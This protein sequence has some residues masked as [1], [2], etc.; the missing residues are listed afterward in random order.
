[1]FASQRTVM[2]ETPSSLVFPRKLDTALRDTSVKSF[3]A[4]FEMNKSTD[5]DMFINDN[6]QI[7]WDEDMIKNS[8]SSF[9]SRILLHILTLSQNGILFTKKKIADIGQIFSLLKDTTQIQLQWMLN[10]NFLPNKEIL[11]TKIKR[12]FATRQS[13]VVLQNILSIAQ[14]FADLIEKTQKIKRQY[15]KSKRGADR[16]EAVIKENHVRIDQIGLDVVWSERLIAFKFKE[17]WYIHSYAYLLLIHNKL[18]DLLSVLVYSIHAEGNALEL[19][20][21]ETTIEFVKLLC[22]YNITYGNKFFGIAK[23]LEAL[24][25]AETLRQLEEWDNTLFLK[26]LQS[27]LEE[28]VG[29]SYMDSMLCIILRKATIPFRHELAGLS[30]IVG[31]PYVDMKSGTAKLHEK[32]TKTLELDEIAIHETV[33]HAKRMFIKNYICRHHKW[34]NVEMSE[35]C[36]ESIR[37]AIEN[38]RDPDA[39]SGKRGKA[40]VLLSD[41][42]HISILKCMEFE[43]LENFIPYLKDKTVS[44][45][46]KEV[47]SEI[48]E[49]K[50]RDIGEGTMNFKW[51]E[52]RLLLV[53]LLNPAVVTDHVEFMKRYEITTDFQDLLNYLVIRIVPK[54]KELKEDYRG[55]GCKTVPER[56]RGQTQESNVK[57]Y[58][59][60]YVTESAMPLG[61]LELANRLLSFR[62]IGKAYSGYKVLRINV[63]ASSWNNYFRDETVAPVMKETLD[64]VFDKPIFSKTHKCYENTL[65]YVDDEY[66]CWYWEGQ[67]GGIEGL[68]QDTWVATYI[69]QLH[70]IMHEYNYPY[71]LLCKGDDLRVVILVPPSDDMVDN[72]KQLSTRV[73]T[74]IKEQGRKLGHTIKVEDSYASE[75]YFAFSKA[76]S[77]NMIELPQVYRKI[78]KCY[79]AN[80]AFLPFLDEYSGASFSNAHS[81]SKTSPGGVACYQ[82]ALFWFFFYLKT[83]KEYSDCSTSQLTSLALTPSLV[84]GFPIIYLHNMFVRAESDLLSP[85]IS[86]CQYV[87]RFNMDIYICMTNFLRYSTER[88]RSVKAL[89]LDPY[90]V[91]VEKPMTPSSYLRSMII[92][93]L[94]SKTKNEHILQLFEQDQKQYMEEFHKCMLS[95]NV[96]NPK[97]MSIIYG[98]TPEGLILQL[99]KKFETG[100]SIVELIIMRWGRRKADAILK[101]VIRADKKVHDWRIKRMMGESH[102]T[103]Q[104]KF[105]LDMNA[106]PS[107]LANDLRE[108]SWQKTVEG[109]T[110]PPPAHTLSF[111][112]LITS[113]IQKDPWDVDHHFRFTIHPPT[114]VLQSG[115]SRSYMSSGRRP[116]L[117]HTTSPGTL[118]PTVQ[119]VEKD[120]VLMKVKNCLELMSWTAKE[121]IVDGGEP[122]VSN[123]HLMIESVLRCYSSYTGTDLAPFAGRRRAGTMA[124]HLKAPSF[125]ES[126]VP[127]ELSNVY[128]QISGESNT[129]A[130]FRHS[131]DHFYINFLHLFCFSVKLLFFELE[132]DK[133]ITTPDHVW[134]ITSNC[135]YCMRVIHET[136]LTIDET[137][138]PRSRPPQL[139]TTRIGAFSKGILEASHRAFLDLNVREADLLTP[140]SR[141]D[142]TIGCLQMVMDFTIIRRRIIQDYAGGHSLTREGIDVMGALVQKSKIKDVGLRVLKSIPISVLVEYSITTIFLEMLATFKRLTV[143]SV[144]NLMLTTP[145]GEL[146]WHG[147][148]MEVQ[149]AGRLG[150]FMNELANQSQSSLTQHGWNVEAATQVCGIMVYKAQWNIRSVPILVIFSYYEEENIICHV[151]RVWNALQWAIFNE[152]LRPNLNGPP[153]P[154]NKPGDPFYDEWAVRLPMHMSLVYCHFCISYEI[155]HYNRIF[156][157]QLKDTGVTENRMFTA[158]DLEIDLL[159][160]PEEVT[161]DHPL[162]S[163]HYCLKVYRHLDWETTFTTIPYTLTQI[164]EQLNAIYTE[165]PLSVRFTDYATCIDAAREPNQEDPLRAED[166]EALPTERA[167]RDP[168][169]RKITVEPHCNH[170]RVPRFRLKRVEGEREWKE[171]DYSLPRWTLNPGVNSSIIS[172]TTDVATRL[173]EIL[174]YAKL[175]HKLP[176]ESH[177]AVLADG[178]GGFASVLATLFQ[179]GLFITC[180]RLEDIA[181]EQR[182][183]IAMPALAKYSH[184]VEYDHILSGYDNLCDLHTMMYLEQL[185]EELAVVTCDAETVEFN[186]EERLTLYT[187][188]V[189]Y[190]LRK[191]CDDGILIVKGYLVE[192]RLLA[193]VLSTLQ[194]YCH[195][196]VLMSL[197]SSRPSDEVYI[198]AQG[199]GNYAEARS[200]SEPLHLCSDNIRKGYDKFVQRHHTTYS[201]FCNNLTCELPLRPL[202]CG[203]Y[204]RWARLFNLNVRKKLDHR[205][206]LFGIP[207]NLKDSLK[208]CSNV[209]QLMELS[210]LDNTQELRNVASMVKD[211]AQVHTIGQ[212]WDPDTITHAGYLVERWLLHAG[213]H[214]GRSLWSNHPRVVLKESNL[215]TSFS[216]LIQS[217]PARYQLPVS[218]ELFFRIPRPVWMGQEKDFYDRY[219]EGC[220]IASELYVAW[221]YCADNAK[222]LRPYTEREEVDIISQVRG[223]QFIRENKEWK[224]QL[225]HEDVL[226]EDEVR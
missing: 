7:N 5:D 207:L 45:Y 187:H 165:W 67:Q 59:D 170:F 105:Y 226:E 70:S 186:T 97:V 15:I 106:C 120:V 136:P 215:R 28:K 221:K 118:E 128:Q 4:R 205:L 183:E 44:L 17:T 31:H 65:F 143:H 56:A 90:S 81:A 142:A 134:A 113:C 50:L 198:W 66:E 69:P 125:R 96:Y 150:E 211:P 130:I 135:E 13:N 82:V 216:I 173:V 149:K 54:E 8:D 23:S 86:L 63:D 6:V 196:V 199:V 139:I 25:I 175:P 71:H 169:L 224:N 147:L 75:H 76:A 179:R 178:M 103:N 109:V 51:E 37:Y 21:Y 202:T 115:I 78:Q 166:I 151:K 99:I 95:M 114:E 209:S 94:E 132:F 160:E 68:N 2:F 19:G 217:L 219:L 208:E 189:N 34:P 197:N 20:A 172:P 192:Y 127:N 168:E 200:L 156:L 164:R 191:R 79:G 100:R 104:R 129:H 110:M 38:N 101:S 39:I 222:S 119:F 1:M 210:Y 177:V 182:P 22:E 206:G 124:H 138:L 201:Q 29:F 30:K 133:E 64:K 162:S 212:N 27:E 108:V 58:E 174:S 111:K 140:I 213:Y 80:N 35:H 55:F 53:Y 116:F 159:P 112:S 88:L 195:T 107:Q 184:V 62:R 204:L 163:L 14:S 24:C 73:V 214:R 49:K 152:K 117:G 16:I 225:D 57:N 148:L 46:K 157:Q 9:Y 190:Y 72:M 89:M 40:R 220:L 137:L 145:A 32:T 144:G 47:L 33:R 155:D 42:D 77:C 141:A 98:S 185:S 121:L 18:C 61:E 11:Q 161:E 85:F 218:R 123:I 74:W 12:Y 194:K 41:Y 188:V 87:K 203:R 158:D 102:N 93:V 181:V 43:K 48:N 176:D 180:C 171:Y 36:S 83:S 92:P 122:Q 91:N 126:I 167:I 60:Q 84:G 223:S 154:H 3:N 153:R 52:T 193:Y 10:Q 131:S 26:T 146:P